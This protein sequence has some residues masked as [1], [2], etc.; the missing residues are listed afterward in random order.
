MGKVIAC[1][2]EVTGPLSTFMKEQLVYP[3]QTITVEASSN[4]NF[5]L[6]ETCFSDHILSPDVKWAFIY[7]NYYASIKDSQGQQNDLW[8]DIGNGQNQFI[9]EK[10]IGKQYKKASKF[11]ISPEGTSYYYGFKQRVVV[12]NENADQEFH[13]FIIPYIS[14]PSVSYAYF[15]ESEKVRR[16]GDAMHLQILLHQ[17]PD[18]INKKGNY[19]AKIYL[20][21]KEDALKAVDTGDF[22]KHNLLE[23]PFTKKLGFL[24]YNK[25]DNINT[26]IN[27]DFIIDVAWRKNENEE[28]IFVPIIELYETKEKE[29]AGVISYNS[30]QDPI[31]KNFALEPSKSLSKYN[32]KLLGM[33]ALQKEKDPIYS[34]FKVSA[35]FMSDFLDRKEIE[36]NNMIQ[37]IGDINYTKKENNPCAYSLISIKEENKEI[38][39][40]NGRETEI[41]NEYQLVSSSLKDKTSQTFG[42]I[43]GEKK[44]A[45]VVVKAKFLADKSAKPSKVRIA[46]DFKCEKILNDDKPH[47]SLDDVF[48]MGWIVGQWKPSTDFTGRLID[49]LLNF[50]SANSFRFF[51]P[52]NGKKAPELKTVDPYQKKYS[53]DQEAKGLPIPAGTADRF[54]T[55][56][57]AEVQGLNAEDY[58]ISKNDDSITL[59]LGYVYNKTVLDGSNVQNAALDTLW[60]T[61]YLCLSKLKPQTYFV[62]VTTCRYPNQVANIKV[63]PD[64]EW[65]INLKYNAKNPLF[66]YKTPNYGYKTGRNQNYNRGN[67]AR[68]QSERIKTNNNKYEFEYEVGYKYSGED[69][70]YDSSEGIPL[71][72][73]AIFFM[74]AYK[75]A[76]EYLF[77]DETEESESSIARGTEE[78]RVRDE[79]DPQSRLMNTRYAARKAQGQPFRI[80]IDRPSFSGG[81][82]AR[83]TPSSKRKNEIGYAYSLDFAAS[84]LFKI[85]GK[86]DLL[87]YAQFIPYIGQALKAINKVV[88]GVNFL[89]LGAVKI[90][91]YL[92]IAAS[93]ALDI[94]WKGLEYHSIDGWNVNKKIGTKIA[95]KVWLESGVNLKVDLEGVGSGDAEAAIKGEAS[96]DIALNYDTVSHK[97][98]AEV[99]FKGLKV[100]IW[101]KLKAK[102]KEQRSEGPAEE[103]A[104]DPDYV[105]DLID[106]MKKPW[107]INIM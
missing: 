92:N 24:D 20:L 81:L 5:F 101:I 2:I 49:R 46:P 11:S 34:E 80:E 18:N 95:I 72:N 76:R 43:S 75:I 12:F 16:Y 48:K 94:D 54:K 104:N 52:D 58:T 29:I 73:A 27:I 50:G 45:S 96:I 91:Y 100:K 102:R 32:A 74:D 39:I 107:K 35:E 17:Y 38:E 14:T 3:G 6:D 59:K 60:V 61:N 47:S 1:K 44:K 40:Y 65:W 88:E 30:V 63:Y 23:K 53:N 13:F 84:P 55:V 7:E 77:A 97:S 36:K 26:I 87:F 82:Y 51:H 68:Y 62:P 25:V 99:D 42:V 33:E 19:E 10:G 83:F 15:N 22:E 37:Y 69:Y 41:F 66:V 85:T 28:K 105:K 4:V 56:S 67:N 106:G 86:L 21:K 78:V 9:V 70:K 31:I 64:F 79:R 98:D 57:V 89:T 103:P 90:D 8:A 93:L 71:L